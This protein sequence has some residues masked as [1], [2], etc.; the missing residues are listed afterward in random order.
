MFR[1]D[2]PR[3]AFDLGRKL[4]GK[5]FEPAALVHPCRGRWLICRFTSNFMMGIE[6]L[7]RKELVGLFM[8]Q[9]FSRF[10]RHF[11]LYLTFV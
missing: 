5:F 11:G 8:P 3:S 7:R 4:L 6:I 2:C 10:T 1:L 9:N